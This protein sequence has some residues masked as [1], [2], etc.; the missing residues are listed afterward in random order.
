MRGRQ[1][2]GVKLD[3]EKQEDKEKQHTLY[4]YSQKYVNIKAEMAAEFVRDVL[5]KE[6]GG[7]ERRRRNKLEN[8]LKELF[9]T[10][11]PGKHFR[12]ATA[13]EFGNIEFPVTVGEAQHD[14][15]DLSSGEK[16]I[17]YGYLKLRRSAW[18]DSIILIDEPELHLNPKLI[19][20]LP[21]FYQRHVVAEMGNQMWLVT[22]SDALLREALTTPRATVLHMQEAG[23][24][25]IGKNQLKRV[26]ENRDEEHAV[27]EMVGDIAA[28]R[29]QAKI[30][31]FE[32]KNSGFDIKMTS[33]LFPEYEKKMNFIAGGNKAGVE[34]LHKWLEGDGGQGVG[35]I[36]SIVDGDSDGTTR[37]GQRRFS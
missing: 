28:Y 29:P 25:E 1:I 15:N 34:R 14:M 16:E 20:G 18:K 21:Q 13:D 32:G 37:I 3:L 5:Q 10:F 9:S 17:L 24:G 8:T 12:G 4:N 33:R 36:Y 30:V 19:Q 11:F 6:G 35:Q 26:E 31:V 27:M 7:G 23:R 22:H 2:A